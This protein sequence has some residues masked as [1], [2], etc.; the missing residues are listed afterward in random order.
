MATECTL[1]V[2]Y[3]EYYPNNAKCKEW[4]ERHLPDVFDALF[5]TSKDPT[6]QSAPKTVA[7]SDVKS[8]TTAAGAAAADEDSVKGVGETRGRQKRGGKAL[9][10]TK[11]KDDIERY[12]KLARS[13]RGKKKYVTVVTGLST[14]DIDIKVAAKFFAS[15]FACGS[16]VTGTDEIVIQGD[17]KDDMFDLL[18]E[19]WPDIDEDSIEDLGN[20]KK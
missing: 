15:K 7:G 5:K 2:E 9:V 8:D 10:K 1:P 4:L 11:K 19:K 17:V 12:V 6:T 14:Y 16:S 18:T 13:N 20:I 3:C